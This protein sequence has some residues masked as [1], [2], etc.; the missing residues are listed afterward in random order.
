MI[1]HKREDVFKA[2]LNYFN[3]DELAANVW[4]DK[5]ALKDVDG[6]IFELTPDDMH[7]RLA[8]EFARIESKYPNS[9]SEDEIYNLFKNFKYIIPQGSPMAGIGNDKQIVSLSNCFVIGNNETSDSYGSIMRSDEELV[10][11]FKRRA[12]SGVD[13]S[14]LRPS[15]S[16][17]NN[18]VL[19]GLAGST[20][21]M[22]RYSNSTREVS[23]GGR[24]GAL[25][26]SINIKHPDSERFIDAKMEQGKVTGANVSVK[27]T[28]EFMNAV[29]NDKTYI[30]TFPV[31]L[32]VDNIKYKE[33]IE[34][35]DEY[36]S[37]KL[38]SLGEGQYIQKTNAKRLWKKI[39]DN[40]WKSAEPGVLFIDNIH[41]ESPA[42]GYGVDW[43]ELSTN[44]CFGGDEKLLTVNGYKTF[45]ELSEFDSIKI[46]NSVGNVVES[47]VW[48]S[49]DKETIKFKN[50]IGEEFVC[51]PDHKW[52]LVD[53]D[54]CEAKDLKGKK[55]KKF[56]NKN[57]QNFDDKFVKLG[58]IQG[59]AVLS[60]LKS[61][62]HKGFEIIIGE[63]D[64]DVLELFGY[65]RKDKNQIK[66]YVDEF[67]DECIELEFDASTLPNRCLPKT[68]KDWEV[69]KKISFIR[70]LYSANGSIIKNH[71]ISFKSTS[72]ELIKE[73]K[74][75]FN[76]LNVSSYYTTNKP[77]KIKFKNGEYLVKESYDLNISKYNDLVYFYENI[78]FIH[79]YKN[80]SLFD[81]INQKTP[82][83]RSV[84]SNGVQSV[85]DFIEPENHWGVINGYVGSNCGEIPLCPYDSCRLLLM[86]LYG[87]VKKPFTREAYFDFDK[88]DKDSKYAQKLMDDLIDL[89]I[90]KIDK[91][92]EKIQND[93]EP[94]DIKFVE[95]NLWK[96]IKNKA[97]EGRRTGLGITGE[98]DML[99]ALNLV[100]GSENGI[101]FSEKIHKQLA[102]NS[103][104]SSIEMARDRGC[105]P[106]WKKNKDVESNFINRILSELDE[107]YINLFN[108]H[109]R[110][111]IANLTIAPAGTVSL[112]TQT[113]SGV[114]PVFKTFY[115]RRRKTDDKSKSVYV[116]EVGDMW[117]EYPVFHQKFIEWY[118]IVNDLTYLDSKKVLE[119]LSSTDI[120]DLYIKSPYY[121]SSSEDVYY[122][123]KV[124]LQGKIQ[125]WVDHSISVTVNMPNN[126]TK[127][128][129]SDV[130]MK[131]FD[132]NCK[133]LTIYRDG[134]RGGVL[135]TKKEKEVDKH[136]FSD[137][138]APKRP[139]RLKG[140]IH[141]FQ[142]NL[143]KWIA[144]VGIKDGRPYELFTGRLQNGL[145]ELPVSIKDCE[146]VKKVSIDEN[147]NKFK[148]YN[149]EYVDTNGNKQVYEGIN[150]TF[151][152]EF[153]NYGKLISGIFR[154]GMPLV[155]ALELI[156]S[157]SFSEE[158]INSW[159]NGVI[160]V[161]KRYIK[162][163][164]KSKG[165][166]PVCGGEDFEFKEG[167]L[168]CT[169]CSWSKCS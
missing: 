73:I 59:D 77:K 9:L 115:F 41:N 58:F 107:E 30:Q 168:M 24:R 137:N 46:I 44:P 63:D 130:Y 83:I 134:S 35:V 117:E 118:S 45:K 6:G 89:E 96:K 104:K 166:C 61:E 16:F 5:Y 103:Y 142:N 88:F 120:N 15:N 141:R 14:H 29:K 64:N 11:L 135:I 156:E 80:D 160:R 140:E 21:Y 124:D 159:K 23:Q 55:I 76:S 38:Y 152:P 47:N 126:I 85:Y 95:L 71:R 54:E 66:W 162:D 149:M 10:Q 161:I 153:W 87:Y 164:E 157:L 99:A 18:S 90:E 20:L 82:I 51:T 65:E 36:E 167:C 158:H 60:R 32:S 91:L 114:E 43:R 42:K 151:N 78:G 94:E 92:I 116:D 75:F 7:R 97:I 28:S 69:N 25:M 22:E 102:I 13:I 72:I 57:H 56:L 154:H 1:K 79:K 4:I 144:V 68:F 53:G 143:E 150:K 101:N 40:A 34:R 133:G 110:R 48:K 109:G 111:N 8:K 132:S 105:F 37:D 145:S 17:A 123:G 169:G 106:I 81:L 74:E 50:S 98:G 131:G 113:T 12:G 39:T 84:K 52:F 112:M 138:H 62:T 129:V 67:Y 122:L 33:F 121:K 86:N 2:S 127:E 119:S 70:G 165:E 3:G 31:D 19:S 128:I 139:K 125:K 147:G 108:I 155:K 93:P 146:V 148:Q 26:I 27:I 49:G 100:Y 136:N 163:G